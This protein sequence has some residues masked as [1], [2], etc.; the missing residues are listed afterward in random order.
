MG[1]ILE[2]NSFNRNTFQ[3]KKKKYPLKYR[4]YFFFVYIYL[5][6]RGKTGGRFTCLKL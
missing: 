1:D 4:A 6:D 5:E 2:K 3:Q